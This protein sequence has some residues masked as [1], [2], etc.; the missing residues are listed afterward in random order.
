[1]KRKNRN[2]RRQRRRVPHRGLP[3]G[4]SRAAALGR[5]A[6]LLKVRNGLVAFAVVGGAG[7]YLAEEVRATS[8]EHDLSRL[9][10]GK[11]TVVQ[12]HDPGCPTCKALQRETRDALEVFDPDEIQYLVAN[13][14]TDK[15]RAFAR[16]HRV[17][18]VTLLLFDGKGNHRDTLAGPRTART[19][20]R[21]FRRH[22][23]RS[24]AG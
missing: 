14:R 1:M 24:T 20:E 10:N 13:I 9:G 6:A 2:V 4:S 23:K 16:A 11:A 18:H 7:W 5:R 15:G 19:L 12:I 22:V 21:V 8:R 17:G 3:S